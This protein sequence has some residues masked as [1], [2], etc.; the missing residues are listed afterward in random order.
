MG[1][2]EKQAPEKKL[3]CAKIFPLVRSSFNK[4]KPDGEE[5]LR[6][7]IKISDNGAGSELGN[8]LEESENSKMCDALNRSVLRFSISQLFLR[9]S[10]MP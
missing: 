3:S 2:K 5:E 7:R 10:P 9:K 6:F 8:K 4:E 1:V